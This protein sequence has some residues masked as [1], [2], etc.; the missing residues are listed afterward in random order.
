[1]VVKECQILKVKKVKEVRFKS[2]LFALMG[3]GLC[4][5]VI[6][7]SR[8]LDGEGEAVYSSSYFVGPSDIT[9]NQEDAF[10]MHEDEV[11]VFSS[12]DRLDDILAERIVLVDEEDLVR[13][14][15]RQWKYLM[16]EAVT[17]YVSMHQI[18]A[19]Q[20]YVLNTAI[21]EQ[22]WGRTEFHLKL[23]DAANTLLTASYSNQS[24]SDYSYDVMVWSSQYSSEEREMRLSY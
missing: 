5:L 12:R 23:N 16:I 21:S 6:L 20:V 2:Y 3:I 9:V 4:S 14:V 7:I 13:P 1:M 11:I 18:D 22:D 8:M 15:L 17:K 24:N 10:V 19:T